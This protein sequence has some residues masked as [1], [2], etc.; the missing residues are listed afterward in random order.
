MVAV[1]AMLTRMQK[2]ILRVLRVAVTG[3]DKTVRDK[4]VLKKEV[5]KGS[6][7]WVEVRLQVKQDH[8]E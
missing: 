6:L 8:T 2:V 1:K 7:M 4:I 5:Q 3:R